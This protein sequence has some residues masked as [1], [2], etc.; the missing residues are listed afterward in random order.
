MAEAEALRAVVRRHRPDL[1]IPEIE[2][3]ADLIGELMLRENLHN[4]HVQ[5]SLPEEAVQWRVIDWHSRTASYSDSGSPS[6]C[7]RS[8]GRSTSLAP[9]ACR[10]CAAC[11]SRVLLGGSGGRSSVSVMSGADVGGVRGRSWGHCYHKYRLSS[12]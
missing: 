2:A 5:A 9:S 1:V 12:A 8:L 11:F 10:S 7:R 3:L 4:A 6:I